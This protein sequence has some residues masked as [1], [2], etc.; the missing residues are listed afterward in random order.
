LISSQ[1]LC[2]VASRVNSRDLLTESAA[3]ILN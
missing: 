1:A 2:V 3:E